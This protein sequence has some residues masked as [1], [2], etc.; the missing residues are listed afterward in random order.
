MRKVYLLLTAFACFVGCNRTDTSHETGTQRGQGSGDG[1]T[2]IGMVP[3][4]GRQDT[5]GGVTAG[6]TRSQVTAAVTGTA[7]YER[8]GQ[9]C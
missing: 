2:N 3:G 4:S 9:I 7:T 5:G 8:R 6:S 1:T